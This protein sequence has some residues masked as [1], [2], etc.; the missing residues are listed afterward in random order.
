MKP[1][2]QPLTSNVSKSNPTAVKPKFDLKASLSKPLGY[3]PYTGP[4]KNTYSGDVPRKPL[5]PGA[6]KPA[7]L[8]KPVN[9]AISENKENSSNKIEK[10]KSAVSKKSVI[11]AAVTSNAKPVNASIW[12]RLMD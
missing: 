7:V 5:A 11:A 2:Q 6:S 4:L 1:S 10:T 3:K 8:S 12:V 9:H